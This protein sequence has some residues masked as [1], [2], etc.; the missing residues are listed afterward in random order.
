MPIIKNAV[1]K[2]AVCGKLFR[3]HRAN[4][5]TCDAGCRAVYNLYVP[6]DWRIGKCEACGKTFMT[7]QPKRKYC[8]D[9]CRGI[10]NDK[11][12]WEDHVCENPECGKTFRRSTKKK[13]YCCATCN[14]RVKSARERE[15]RQHEQT[16]T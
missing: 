13:K 8:N 11:K 10:G 7:R 3:P 5:K 14:A 1:R 15:K 6:K 16:A 4:Q 2:C 12:V 9:V